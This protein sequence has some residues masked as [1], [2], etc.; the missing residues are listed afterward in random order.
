MIATLQ[1]AT[2][3]SCTDMLC[4]DV[5]VKCSSHSSERLQLPLR[6]LTF[7]GFSFTRTASLSTFMTS[8][9]E[10]CFADSCALRRLLLSLMADCFE[11][12]PSTSTGNRHSEQAR[13]AVPGMAD[14]RAVVPARQSFSAG[15]VATR[16]CIGAR[17]S[18]FCLQLSQC[19]LAT[20]AMSDDVG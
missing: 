10:I 17:S 15:L 13:Q 11:C 9:V 20:R 19:R 6:C 18:S 3:D 8:T 14:L 12:I 16:N 7:N 1:L 4:F 2:T 5:F